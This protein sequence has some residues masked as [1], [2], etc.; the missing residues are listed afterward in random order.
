[1]IETRR[2]LG[3]AGV[4]A[5][6]AA[7]LFF[8]FLQRLNARAG[9]AAAARSDAVVMTKQAEPGQI[10]TEDMVAVRRLPPGDIPSDAVLNVEQAVDKISAVRL[11][12]G[13]VLLTGRLG[14]VERLS[15]AGSVPQ[16]HVAFALSVK[17]HEGVA[18]LIA[19][20]DFVDVIGKLTNRS[21]VESENPPEI[22]LENV[23]VVGQAGEPPLADPVT[24][25]VTPTPQPPNA[26]RILIL[27]LEP[28]QAARLATALEAGTV[29]VALR[30]SRQ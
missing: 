11:F 2:Y 17:P 4:S 13:E 24:A 3:I 23:R 21:S 5:L 29:Y 16:G 12:P 9:A 18:G 6:A 14:S 10:I 8:V 1:M 20:G 15:A 27:D 19:P 25:D 30:S 28:L 26:A 7:L 22:L